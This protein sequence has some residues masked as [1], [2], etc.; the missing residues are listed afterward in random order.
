MVILTII[1]SIFGGEVVLYV[2]GE[3]VHVRQLPSPDQT[4]FTRTEK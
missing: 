1:N 3:S 4:Q 2:P